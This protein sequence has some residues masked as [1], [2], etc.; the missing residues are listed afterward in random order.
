MLVLGQLTNVHKLSTYLTMSGTNAISP[1]TDERLN[2][3]R[4]TTQ[5]LRDI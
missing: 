3:E 2:D 4:R 1:Q 5:Q